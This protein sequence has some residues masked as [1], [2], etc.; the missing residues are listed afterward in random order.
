[1]HQK[2]CFKNNQTKLPVHLDKAMNSYNLINLFCF[3]YLIYQTI[4]S[5][6]NFPKYVNCYLEEKNA[7]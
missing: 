5:Y 4:A 1:M 7:K 2:I 3:V 6:N